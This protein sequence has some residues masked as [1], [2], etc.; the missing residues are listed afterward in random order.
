V[1]G[2]WPLVGAT[3]LAV[4]LMVVLVLAIGGVT[5][6]SLLVSI[7]ATALTSF[8]LFLSAFLASSARTVWKTPLTGWLIRNRRYLGVSFA[9]SH[10]F[11]L[12]AIASHSVLTGQT[13]NPVT[14]VAGGLAYAFIAAMV[15]TS[16]DRT[17]AWLGPARWRRLHVTGMYYV[18]FIFTYT[19]I[20]SSS[21]SRAS[22]FLAVVLVLA[23]LARLW[24]RRRRQPVRNGVIG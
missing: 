14:T 3:A 18:W 4:G 9:A 20:G 8:V 11:H 5:E 6:V 22:G 17:A 24:I 12:G 7:R 21:R 23:L 2:G 13:P 16:F 19:Y 10:T 1:L 15:A